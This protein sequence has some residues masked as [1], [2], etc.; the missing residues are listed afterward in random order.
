MTSVAFDDTEKR[1]RALLVKDFKLDPDRLTLDARLDELG[2]DS[3]GMAELIFNV[4]DEFGLKLADVAVQLSTF[5]EVVQFI[6][7]AVADQRAPAAPSPLAN[8]VPTAT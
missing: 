6:D 1:I 3:I 8:G 7:D 5:G 2:V 4:E